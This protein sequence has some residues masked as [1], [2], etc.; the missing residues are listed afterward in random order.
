METEHIDEGLRS[1]LPKD[2]SKAVE[3]PAEAAL[4]LRM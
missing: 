2:E 3:K 4:R 1:L